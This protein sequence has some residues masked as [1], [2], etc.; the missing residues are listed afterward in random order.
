[1]LTL[2]IFV[3]I[4]FVL[5]TGCQWMS[6]PRELFGSASSIHKYFRQWLK[7]GFFQALWHAGLAEYD[8]MEGIAWKLQSV[9]EP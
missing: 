9:D 6:L 2:R 4:V 8:E 5:K 3:V 1:M 7:A